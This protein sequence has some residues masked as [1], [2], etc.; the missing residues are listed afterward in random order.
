MSNIA[1]ALGQ[2]RA[3]LGAGWNLHGYLIF[4]VLSRLLNFGWLKAQSIE[5]IQ[6]ALTVVWKW[7]MDNGYWRMNGWYGLDARDEINEGCGLVLQVLLELQ[8]D[9]I[10]IQ[11]RKTMPLM[12]RIGMRVGTCLEST[13]WNYNHDDDNDDDTAC[14][15]CTTQEDDEIDQWDQAHELD[16]GN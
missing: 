11:T 12:I 15:D 13:I 3:S 6:A 8:I 7:I 16:H 9:R 4:V 14:V 2:S 5:K 1:I 10:S